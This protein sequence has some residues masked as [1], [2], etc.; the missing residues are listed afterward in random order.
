MSRPL[1]FP[2]A[3]PFAFRGGPWG[4]GALEFSLWGETDVVFLGF[5]S[6]GLNA[7]EYVLLVVLYDSVL[8]ECG[9]GDVNNLGLSWPMR[10]RVSLGSVFA[11][12]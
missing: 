6:F 11:Y 12:K 2:A 4:E 1:R 8:V 10:E 7:C 3:L 9:S 5:G